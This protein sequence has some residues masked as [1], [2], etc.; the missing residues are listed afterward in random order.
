MPENETVASLPAK[1]QVRAALAQRGKRS[2]HRRSEHKLCIVSRRFAERD[3]WRTYLQGLGFRP[4]RFRNGHLA[5]PLFYHLQSGN[6]ATVSFFEREKAQ[7]MPMGS[8]MTWS[9]KVGKL[10]ERERL[11]DALGLRGDETVLDVG[12]GRGLLLNAA[13]RRLTTMKQ[14]RGPTPHEPDRGYSSVILVCW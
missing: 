1:P 9:S 2:L 13:A 8:I 12:C 14:G 11:M 5:E 10:R 3:G 7:S 4:S 6:C